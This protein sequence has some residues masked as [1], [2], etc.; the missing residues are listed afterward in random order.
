[1]SLIRPVSVHTVLITFTF[2]VSHQTCVCPHC[3]YNIYFFVSG[4]TCVFPH[5]SYIYSLVPQT[6]ERLIQSLKD[7]LDK[8]R[9]RIADLDHK[10]MLH[11]AQ[12]EKE[13]M[14]R[15]VVVQFSSRWYLCTWKS[16]YAL[17]PISQKFAC[18]MVPV[19][20]GLMMV[21]CIGYCIRCL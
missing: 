18:E 3:S 7:D 12:R 19:F 16:P 21:R 17:H 15:Y 1:M 14:Q 20:I 11:D 10:Q 4:Q 13:R 8:S 6:R 9:Q 5:C 2:F